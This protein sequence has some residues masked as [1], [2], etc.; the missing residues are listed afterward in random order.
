MA[1]ALSP[2][3][4]AAEDAAPPVKPAAPLPVVGSMPFWQKLR[5][6]TLARLGYGRF[7]TENLWRTAVDEGNASLANRL[8]AAGMVYPVPA[9][10]AYDGLSEMLFD[11][12]RLLD[13]GRMTECLLRMGANPNHV[14]QNNYWDAPTHRA[15]RTRNAPALLAMIRHGADLSLR[16]G[17]KFTPALAVLDDF[18]AQTKRDGRPAATVDERWALVEVCMA[19]GADPKTKGCHDQTLL[20]YAL[21]DTPER[22]EWVLS[23]GVTVEHPR[24]ALEDVFYSDM[25]RLGEGHLYVRDDGLARERYN[26]NKDFRW[27]RAGILAI[28]EREG[29][30]YT[31]FNADNRTFLEEGIH[32]HALVASDVAFLVAKGAPLDARDSEGNTLTHQL[33]TDQRYANEAGVALYDALRLAGLPDQ[34]AECNAAGQTPAD[35]RAQASEDWY[36]RQAKAFDARV[37]PP[38]ATAPV[39]PVVEVTPPAQPDPAPPRSRLRRR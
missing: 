36:V 26:E 12:T 28:L 35:A 37:A 16:D 14:H 1:T 4:P 38:A 3:A 23:L 17:N 32:R 6:R 27:D 33:F 11:A 19:N 21:A 31:G 5:F 25:V 13:D 29:G 34:R 20:S 15:A 22:V 18:G 2:A 9:K 10:G 39:A 8:L 7:A 24:Q 30:V